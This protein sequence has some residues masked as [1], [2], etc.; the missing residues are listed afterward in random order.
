MK[1]LKVARINGCEAAGLRDS[2]YLWRLRVFDTNWFG[3]YLHVFHRSDLDDM[4]DHPWNFMSVI[5]WNGYTEV[6]PTG[7]SYYGVGSVLF[8]PAAHT[9]KVVIDENRKPITLVIR[10]KYIREW[11]FYAKTGWKQW[12]EYFKEMG[13]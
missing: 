7:E 1:I 4:H 5:L 13:C 11:G 10:F 12:Q 9:H 6:T 3:I 2:L 8:R